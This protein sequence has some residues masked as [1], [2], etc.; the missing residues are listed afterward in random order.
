MFLQFI[1]VAIDGVIS[2]LLYKIVSKSEVNKSVALG[3]AWV[4]FVVSPKDV[5]IAEFANMQIWF[6]MLLCMMLF[7][8]DRTRKKRYLILSALCLCLTILSYPSCLIIFPVT[9]VFFL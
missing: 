3:M 1:G 5:P 9:V 8:Y 7:L 6:S 4:F 2:Y